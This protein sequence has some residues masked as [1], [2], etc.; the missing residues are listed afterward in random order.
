MDK[1]SKQ[2]GLRLDEKL[3]TRLKNFEKTTGIPFSILVRNAIEVALDKFE[4]D[5]K[6][7]FPLSEVISS[8]K[9][10][11]ERDAK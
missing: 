5:N 11:A 2:I 3:M 4:Q 7:T 9:G 8:G 10:K 1:K 6:I